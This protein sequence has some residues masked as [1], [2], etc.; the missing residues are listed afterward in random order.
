[1]PRAASNAASRSAANGRLDPRRFA[2]PAVRAVLRRR[3]AELLGVLFA[4]AALALTVALL[5]Y[6]PADPSLNTATYRATHNLVGPAGAVAS[7]QPQRDSA[8]PAL[9]RQPPGPGQQAEHRQE[10][11]QAEAL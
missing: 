2:S 11:G 7:D 4:L 5:T 1:M 6:D 10:G 8:E 3:M 9:R